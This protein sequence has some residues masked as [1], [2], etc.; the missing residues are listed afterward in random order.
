MSIITRDQIIDL[1]NAGQI[2]I[3]RN[4][5]V[6]SIVDSLSEIPAT[7]SD[8]ELGVETLSVSQIQNC[9]AILGIQIDG[10][11]LNNQGLI[12]D[13]S[14]NRLVWATGGGGGGTIN[15]G[16]TGEL[17]YYPA[18]GS[19]VD[20][21]SLFNYSPTGNPTLV[22]NSNGPTLIELIES[23]ASGHPLIGG[24]SCL[25]T[26]NAPSIVNYHLGYVGSQGSWANYATWNLPDRPTLVFDAYD[27]TGSF[28][29]Q[30]GFESDG[31]GLLFYR[32]SQVGFGAVYEDPAGDRYSLGSISYADSSH[33]RALS[34]AT[35]GLILRTPDVALA[36]G[37][38][39]NSEINLWLDESA[40]KLKFKI[41]DSSG[42]IKVAEL[43]Y[44]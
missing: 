35:D 12:Y 29:S 14:L 40:S 16:L 26:L 30:V 31:A 39:A 20:G 22:G 37:V 10:V 5:D 3:L 43:S 38:L 18:N 36:D 33:S 4:G 41:K 7:D 8:I 44:V 1:I 11:P 15:P 17:T 27:S 25:L 42:A 24:Y 13:L 6:W 28:I 34:W 2:V 21:A 23:G 9:N 32:N 19:M